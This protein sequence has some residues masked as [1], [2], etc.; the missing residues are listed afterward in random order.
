MNVTRRLLFRTGLTAVLSVVVGTAMAATTY[1]VEPLPQFSADYPY[2]S[3][4]A[5]NKSGTVVGTAD[6]FDS[7]VG[8]SKAL[9]WNN[10]GQIVDLAP[11]A[12]APGAMFAGAADINTSGQVALNI[13][14]NAYI[15][16]QG[17][18][19]PLVA[20]STA[21]GINDAGQVTGSFVTGGQQRAFIYDK[22]V[23]SNLGTLPG[24]TGSYGF[25][26]NNTGQVVGSALNSSGQFRAVLWSTGSVVDLGTLP[27]YAASQ[28]YAI[29]DAGQIVGSA[30]NGHPTYNS[31]A[32]LWQNGVMTDLGSVGENDSA[33]AA[34]INNAG[35]IVGSA[36]V[37]GSY[38]YTAFMRSAGSTTNLNLV[39]GNVNASGCQA[40][41]IND[42]GQIAGICSSQP[43]RLTP[44][45]D[46]VDV[47]VDIVTT[48]TYQVYQG[49]PLT[50]T[51]L[52]ANVGSLPASNVSLADVL[53]AQMS[54]VSAVP[55]QGS[56]T[57]TTV[58]TCALGN[59]VVGS[60]ATVLVNV[61]PTATGYNINNTVK[62]SA[63]GNVNSGN[64]S[65][66][67]TN[68]VYPP[69]VLADLSVTTTAAQN[70]VPRRSNIVYTVNV[71]NSGPDTAQDVLLSDTLLDSSASIASYTV[72]HGTCTNSGYYMSCNL[73]SMAN[74][75][76]ATLTLTVKPRYAISNLKYTNAA[77][78]SSKM[79]DSNSANNYATV[80][81]TVK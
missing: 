71:K 66:T 24:G 12:L 49:S 46:A 39:V 48:P 81:V 52:V 13:D 61:T 78:V 33:H 79:Q 56:C 6:F 77:S 45:T 63:D 22:G 30:Y 73:G 31:R 32:F 23:V 64:D 59:L 1:K 2:A 40:S 57:G 70:P 67:A 21:Y 18:L 3:P 14:S 28:A 10:V 58:V 41:A 65:A 34:D 29:N 44:T 68:T 53:P 75:A 55:S 19:T 76:T 15:V 36:H 42:A 47:G 8:G 80:T 50:Y 5:I 72:T 16:D 25:D 38:R 11:A 17:V 27:G 69:L 37:T 51:I 7:D 26:I 4:A 35:Q 60:T 43:Y 74:G 9:L 62:V 54:F 20:G